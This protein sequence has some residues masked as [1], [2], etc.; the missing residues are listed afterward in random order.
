MK[1]CKICF[2][3]FIGFVTAFIL[4]TVLV[5]FV[6]VQSIGPK[7][8]SVGLAG[9][10]QCIHALT[11]VHLSLYTLTDWLGL[12]PIG[13][14]MGF[15]ALGLAQWIRRKHIRAVEPDILMLGAFYLVTIAVYVLFESVVVNYRPILIDGRLEVSYP[16]STTVLTICVMSTAMLQW[17]KR[18]RNKTFRKL[19][20]IVCILFTVFMVVGRLLSGVHWFSD[21]VGGVLCSAGLVMMY[22]SLYFLIVQLRYLP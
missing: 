4:W 2:V 18:I 19:V 20:S 14:C 22:V 3:A 5:C 16:S 11:G 21:I 10:N 17:N 7:S 8:S 6:D 12:I 15:G 1:N 13:V 9:I